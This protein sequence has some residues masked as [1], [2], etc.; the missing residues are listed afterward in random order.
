MMLNNLLPNHHL[1]AIA[2][3]GIQYDSRKVKPGDLFFATNGLQVDG[4][5]FVKA[6]SAV[7]AAVLCEAPYKPAFA[8]D[9]EIEDLSAQKGEVASR[10][11]GSPSEHLNVIAV[12]GTNGK[13]SVSHYVAQAFALIGQYCG[14]IGTLGAGINGD[15]EDIGM[16]TPDAVDLQRVLSELREK[17]AEVVCLEASSH[18][19]EQG[20]LNGTRVS[21][22]IFTNIT[23]DHL[24][25][26]E[27]F[28]SYAAAKK[29]LFNWPKLKKTVLNLDDEFGELLSRELK[30]E[31][32]VSDELSINQREVTCMTYSLQRNDADIYCSSINY[33]RTGINA[34]VVCGIEESVLRTSLLGGF[35]LSNLLAVVATLLT[36]DVDFIVAIDVVSQLKN[37]KGR[38]DVLTVAESPTVVIDYAHTPDALENVLTALK[39]HANSK[40]ICVMGCGGDRY[41]GKRPLM[42]EICGRLA[43]HT[44]VTSDNPRNENP[45]EIVAQICLGFS[46]DAQVSIEIDR[47]SAITLALSIAG[48]EDLVLIAGKGHEEYQDINGRKIQFSDYAVVENYLSGN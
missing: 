12:T 10:F 23:R 7:A 33:D 37:V 3:H 29:K 17:G 19:L 36:H 5:Q 34:T 4:R 24:D 1:P 46:P 40:V 44:I 42:G 26:H 48:I 28:A 2:I 27:N 41:N 39:Q 47:A 30:T 21:L 9:F 25:Y 22:A 31:T 32:A 35:N 14:V 45:D 18:G 15:L 6:V 11:Y 20:R 13:T 43:D 38:M 8:N 16:T